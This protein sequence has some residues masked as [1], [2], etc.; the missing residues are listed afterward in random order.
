M[1]KPMKALL[2]LL[3]RRVKRAIHE[4]YTRSKGCSYN[5]DGLVTFH[6][7][8]FLKDPLFQEA[9]RLGKTTGS[10]GSAD[11]EWRVYVACWAAT[12]GKALEGDF[13]ECGVNKG[14]LSRAVM[15]YIDFRNQRGRQ[16]YL[17]DTYCGFPE[18]Y[19]SLAA[20]SQLHSYRECYQEVQETFK[21]F[22]NVN[23]VRGKVP[24]ILCRVPAEKICYL[25]LDM[26]CAEPEI[27][28]AEHFWP[29][30]V[31][32]AVMVLD[33]YGYSDDYLRQKRAFDA[34]VRTRGVQVLLLPTGQGLIF[35]P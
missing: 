12:K 6:H 15:H 34:F 8:D 28:A 7:S 13:V 31:S 29:R 32:G 20:Q 3:P 30:L 21:E 33:D 18:E 11:I 35:K 4:E 17:L 5:H 27:A 16:F 19:V 1:E 23:I 2:K 22:A 10:W 14:G 25:S 26:N 24:E 9:Y